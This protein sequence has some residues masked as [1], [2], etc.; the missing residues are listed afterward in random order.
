MDGIMWKALLSKENYIYEKLYLYFTKL[1]DE[2]LDVLPGTEE[3]RA[4]C[5]WNR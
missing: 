1:P 5:P 4:E 2:L 3:E